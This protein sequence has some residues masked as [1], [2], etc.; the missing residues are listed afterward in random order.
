M[1]EG[2]ILS[3]GTPGIAILPSSGLLA[4]LAIHRVAS[5]WPTLMAAKAKIVVI[6]RILL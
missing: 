6:T 1:G 4:Q 3:G 2:G 5:A